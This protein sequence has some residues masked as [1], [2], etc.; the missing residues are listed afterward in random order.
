MK[1]NKTYQ[2]T[3][4]ISAIE[5]QKDSKKDYLMNTK[6]IRDPKLDNEGEVLSLQTEVGRI[7][8]NENA[9][10]Q[11][12]TY[13]GVP[14][15]YLQRIK[16]DAT[17]LYFDTISTL[18]EKKE[19]T[20][21][22]IRTYN[23]RARAVLSDTYC[24]LDNDIISNGLQKIADS[25]LEIRG[26]SL[27]ENGM[28][29]QIVSPK[30]EAEVTK[31]DVVQSG[32]VIR[33]SE[34]GWHAM[35]SDFMAYRL[36]CTNGMVMGDKQFQM[37]RVHSGVSNLKQ[38]GN[39]RVPEYTVSDIVSQI[40][41]VAS[42]ATSPE[43]INKYAESM[44]ALDKIAIDDHHAVANRIQKQYKITNLQKEQIVGHYERDNRITA[45]GMCN[46]VTRTAQDQAKADDALHLE[47]IGGNM[48]TNF[49]F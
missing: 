42:H 38:L 37:R 11:L 1:L 35:Q 12:A 29:L 41:N 4:V 48:T 13:L 24:R 36:V 20:P 30:S 34:V 49:A 45:W 8:F 15:P 5:R 16:S 14:A 25:E 32:F 33:N 47:T 44:L 17:D 43:A 28:N 21:R 2:V 31:G 26:F 23:G 10:R 9:E 6:T 46:A 40:E 27:D 22:M 19:D 18:L 3:D 39:E 7:D